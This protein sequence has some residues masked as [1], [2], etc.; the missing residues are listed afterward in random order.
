MLDTMGVFWTMKYPNN[1]DAALIRDWKM[2]AQG[3]DVKIFAPHGFFNKLKEDGV[4]ADAPFA[5]R[6]ADLNPEDWCL[7][8]GIDQ[9]SDAGVLIS[10]LVHTLRA[11]QNYDIPDLMKAVEEDTKS[12]RATKNAVYSHFGRVTGW[13]I[14][15]PT[16]TPLTELAVGGQVTVLDMSV[17]ATLPSGWLIRA[18]VIGLISKKLF[19]QRMLARKNEELTTIDQAVHYFKEKTEKLSQPLVW[20]IVDEAHEVLPKDEKT[21]AT[22]AL[23]TILR[24]GRQPGI[25][26][27]LASQ[28]PGKIHGDVITQSDIVLAHRLTAQAD[29]EALGQLTQTYMREGL[30]QQL[31]MLPRAKGSAVIFDDQNER[32]F[33]VSIRPR[34]TWHGGSSPTALVNTEKTL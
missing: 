10:R 26:L 20:L 32:V 19:T 28:Q 30:L 23:V 9:N 13:G 16:G 22:S 1:E 25:S 27:I 7:T 5:L 15:S 8:F 24:E 14:F 31:D 34:V 21:A 12:E 11:T 3:L 29:A 33:A 2:E 17:Y 18:L 6:P 4:P